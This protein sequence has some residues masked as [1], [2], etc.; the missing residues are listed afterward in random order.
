MMNDF[1]NP[2][3]TLN[4]LD[5]YIARK[6]ILNSIN[7]VIPEFSGTVLDVGCGYMPYKPIIQSSKTKVEK[8]IGLD[9]EENI[10]Q[11]PDLTWDGT[12]IPLDDGSIDCVTAT[13]VFEHCPEIEII[14]KEILRVLKPGGL[15]F[16]TTPFLWPLHTVP[17]DE[18]RYTP[19]ALQR[20]F[21]SAGFEHIQLKALG[22]WDAAL[23]QMLGLWVRRRFKSPETPKFLRVLLSIT[24]IPIMSLILLPILWLLY[25]LDQISRP[26]NNFHE[27][28]MITGLS[29]TAKKPVVNSRLA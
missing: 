11:K 4:N 9:L 12:R 29:G 17:H 28:L 8:Y 2:T 6:S 10:Y 22:G 16:F 25:R 7:L 14:L 20:H 5:S 27:S 1:L 21:E 15:L 18:Y 26:V 13:E 3:I 24:L 19:F 23:G